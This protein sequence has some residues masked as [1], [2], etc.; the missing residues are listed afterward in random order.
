M[1]LRRDGITYIGLVD[2][3]TDTALDDHP[4]YIALG[5]VC[6]KCDREG[7]I[8]R[9]EVRRKWVMRSLA[10]C[11]LASAVSVAATRKATGSFS[12]SCRASLRSAYSKVER[13]S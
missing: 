1:T 3:P 13:T 4:E 10:P 11:S 6:R 12:E 9:H 8:D 5:G 2:E 7:W